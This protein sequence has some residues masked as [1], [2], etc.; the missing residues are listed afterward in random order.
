MVRPPSVTAKDG[1]R[2]GFSLVELII[3]IVILS[4]GVLSMA[5]TSTWVVRQIT[6]SRLSTER[7]VARQSAIE[8]IRASSFETAAGGSGTFGIFDVR[9]TVTEDAGAFKTLE[10][11]TVGLG[12]PPGTGGMLALSPTMAD[13][14]FLTFTGSGF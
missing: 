6:I 12:K 5:G 10:V 1:R 11:V 9:W 14:V 3:S 8:S 13:T 7:T 4:I 2:S